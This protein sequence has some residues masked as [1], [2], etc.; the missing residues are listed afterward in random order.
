MLRAVTESLNIILQTKTDNAENILTFFC[1]SAQWKL[2]YDLNEKFSSTF[3]FL[4]RLF[5]LYLQTLIVNEIKLRE[6]KRLETVV[7]ERERIINFQRFLTR[8]NMKEKKNVELSIFVGVQNSLHF[9]YR[10]LHSS[11]TS[12][13][14]VIT[15][16]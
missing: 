14:P 3:F 9:F 5:L 8:N 4:A 11:A 13:C 12:F 15:G 7:T 16:F 10:F 6:R 1:V 2:H